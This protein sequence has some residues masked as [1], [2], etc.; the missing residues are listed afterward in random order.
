MILTLPNHTWDDNPHGP[1]TKLISW[2][3]EWRAM[4]LL[5]FHQKVAAPSPLVLNFLRSQVR[6]AF[7]SPATR[8]SA[9]K[10]QQRHT[11]GTT[12]NGKITSRLDA[13]GGHNGRRAVVLRS[14]QGIESGG[15]RLA[16]TPLWGN[17]RDVHTKSH[18]SSRS[19]LA[20]VPYEPHSSS[21]GASLP[22]RRPLSTSS[23]SKAW[24]LFGG[25]KQN[26]PL[27]PP[28]LRDALGDL[29]HTSVFE[30]LGRVTRSANELKMRCT[31]L[32]EHGNVTMVSGEFKKTELIAK[33]HLAKHSHASRGSCL[34]L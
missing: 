5:P 2:D 13:N 8:C 27:P 10:K 1:A 6:N 22:A 31:E 11:F 29:P 18:S 28:S 32:D 20:V 24:Q 9:V 17:T 3:R 15:R 4:K 23:I 21:Y 30:G 26:S 33:V 25:R 14:P 16:T 19:S 7:E 34:E 12:S